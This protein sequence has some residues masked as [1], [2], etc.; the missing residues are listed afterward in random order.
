MTTKPPLPTDRLADWARIA[1]DTA[2]QGD[3]AAINRIAGFAAS[4]WTVNSPDGPLAKPMPLMQAVDGAVR[5]ALLHLLE[6]GLIDID[7]DRLWAAHSWPMHR[8][9]NHH[10]KEA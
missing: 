6:L 5:E 10:A 7:T 2:D 8:P 4:S 1:V 3:F 9:R